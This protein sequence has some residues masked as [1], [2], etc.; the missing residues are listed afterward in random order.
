M[1]S[2]RCATLQVYRKDK[3]AT[4]FLLR[5]VMIYLTKL[6]LANHVPSCI[7]GRLSQH[8]ADPKVA[9]RW[10][11]ECLNKHDKCRKVKKMALQTNRP[12]RLINI[13]P[14]DG[15]HDPRL[16]HGVDCSGEYLTRSYCWGDP[17]TITQI[18]K[19]AY[20]K[21]K[22]GIPFAS[23]SQIFR[24]FIEFTRSISVKYLWIDSLCIIQ[25]SPEDKTAEIPQVVEMYAGALLTI[26]A[27]RSTSGQS[28]LF[29]PRSRYNLIRVS[30][31]TDG[32]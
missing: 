13:G 31:P 32:K 20:L 21:F 29:A 10:L 11:D 14:P 25:D 1:I 15:S 7:T 26:L 18:T 4:S 16:E 8:R 23:L 6:L 19:E 2:E 30:D 27:C 22:G 12:S 17:S 3:G 28:S 24:D 5:Q 9:Q